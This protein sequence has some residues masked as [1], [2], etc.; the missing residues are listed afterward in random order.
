MNKTTLTV[1]FL[2]KGYIAEMS[3]EEFEKI[4][5]LKDI[6]VLNMTSFS[7]H[8]TDFVDKKY[9]TNFNKLFGKKK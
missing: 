5:D 4:K 7:V 2:R 6:M 9:K 8:T 3:L 1:A